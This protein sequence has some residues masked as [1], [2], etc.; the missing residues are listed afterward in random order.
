M[1][2]RAITWPQEGAGYGDA[3]FMGI[4]YGL[5]AVVEDYDSVDYVSHD[6]SKSFTNKERTKPQ[7][8]E[9]VWYLLNDDGRSGSIMDIAGQPHYVPPVLDV[10]S[11]QITIRLTVNDNASPV[12]RRDPS[13]SQDVTFTLNRRPC[14]LDMFAS[15]ADPTTGNAIA[16]SPVASGAATT[17]QVKARFTAN[18]GIFDGWAIENVSWTMI[19]WT[20]AIVDQTDYLTS[21]PIPVDETHRRFTAT[22]RVT[23]SNGSIT[24]TD[25]KSK[26]FPLLFDK[27]GHDELIDTTRGR[28]IANVDP[29][30]VVEENPPNWFD[31]RSL[32]WGNVISQMNNSF[33]YY[34]PSIPGLPNVDGYFDWAADL[35]PGRP[36]SARGRIYIFDDAA[37]GSDSETVSGTYGLTV[38]GIDRLADTIVHEKKHR[39]V[40]VAGWGGFTDADIKYPDGTFRPRQADRTDPNGKDDRDND[41][42]SSAYE[43]ANQGTFHIDKAIRFAAQ[44]WWDGNPNLSTEEDAE[45][46]AYLWGEWDGFVVGGY[47]PSDWATGGRNDY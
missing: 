9:L 20:G 13:V 2:I 12:D 31:N 11:K 43:D 27:T 16:L 42:L 3:N 47:D 21:D 15:A 32:H 26:T 37:S 14:I 30:T 10:P 4:G 23:W 22:L 19:P 38:S 18:L 29:L 6:R 40:F 17:D 45:L 7:D 35:E 36:V 28:K 46:I 24:H 1:T 41:T 44:R 34:M 25:T 5:S 39:D 8:F 33:V